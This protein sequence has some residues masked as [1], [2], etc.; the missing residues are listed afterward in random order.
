MANAIVTKITTASFHYPGVK[1]FFTL[2]KSEEN[3]I[4]QKVQRWFARN[5]KG[6]GRWAR[7]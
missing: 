6:G 1:V 4:L 5:A 7:R 2:T 3:A